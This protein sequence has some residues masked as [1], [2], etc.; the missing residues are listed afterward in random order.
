MADA[1]YIPTRSN[2]VLVWPFVCHDHIVATGCRSLVTSFLTTTDHIEALHRFYDDHPECWR[3][4]ITRPRVAQLVG[5]SLE[6]GGFFSTTGSIVSDSRSL[7]EVNETSLLD[8]PVDHRLVPGGAQGNGEEEF[9]IT[10]VEHRSTDSWDELES[11]L[12]PFSSIGTSVEAVLDNAPSPPDEVSEEPWAKSTILYRECLRLMSIKVGELS[13][14]TESVLRR[15]LTGSIQSR[16]EL[17]ELRDS[18]EAL[19]R[20]I[21]GQFPRSETYDVYESVWDGL[22][23]GVSAK[24]DLETCLEAVTSAEDAAQAAFELAE[25]LDAGLTEEMTQ[26]AEGFHGI[27][28]RLGALE[29]SAPPRTTSRL[30][31]RQAALE[32]SPVDSDVLSIASGEVSGG[33]SVSSTARNPSGLSLSSLHG[34][35]VELQQKV[36]D[37]QAQLDQRQALLDAQRAD[38]NA[39]RADLQVLQGDSSRTHFNQFSLQDESSL[40]AFLEEHEFDPSRVAAFCDMD[41]LLSHA[42]EQFKGVTELGERIKLMQQCGIADQSSH[43]TIISF[44]RQYPPGFLTGEDGDIKDGETFPILKTKKVW[45]GSDGRSGARAKYLEKVDTAA[46]RAIAYVGRYTRTGPL[47]EMCLEMIRTSQRFWTAFFDYLNNDLERLVQF[48]ISEKECLVLISEQMKIVFEQVFTKRMMMPEFSIVPGSGVPFDYAAQVL[49]FTLQAHSAMD[50]FMSKKFT[51]HGLLGNTFIRFL[52]RQCG[53]TSVAGFEKRIE[54]LEKALEDSV[55][56]VNKRV[57]E[58]I[59]TVNRKTNAG[60]PGGANPPAA[61]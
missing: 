14:T 48:G 45:V 6:P 27:N 3:D 52:A 42:T 5:V 51:G 61:G 54:K 25:S 18:F 21:H 36:S 44:E 13:S 11:E 55:K 30:A 31:A 1:Y 34:L 46:E 53:N 43:K 9:E 26:V 7:S 2:S 16:R 58:A 8:P 35:I 59:T 37:Q 10:S 32:A 50:D 24:R 23:V 4:I 60:R 57:D 19:L 40:A 17:R 29:R 47:Q 41:S 12:L 28:T 39:L 15:E 38:I 20:D 33:L 22:F 56:K 49:Y